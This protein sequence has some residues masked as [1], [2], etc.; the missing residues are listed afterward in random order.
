MLVLPSSE[1]RRRPIGFSLA[2]F[3][4]SCFRFFFLCLP[5]LS[6]LRV[7]INGDAPDSCKAYAAH[8][9]EGIHEREGW[10]CLVLFS[11][12]S[13]LTVLLSSSYLWRVFWCVLH[14]G[15]LIFSM[16][17]SLFFCDCFLFYLVHSLPTEFASLLLCALY[18]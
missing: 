15:T 5:L 18:E 4:P 13:H 17:S 6:L 3:P 1:A 8:E 2:V 9:R 14:T 11:C 7:G 10:F 16:P 12:I